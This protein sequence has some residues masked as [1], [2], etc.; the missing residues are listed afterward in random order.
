MKES[1]APAV[2]RRLNHA[3]RREKILEAAAKVFIEKG[4]KA[5]TMADLVFASGLSVGGFY[6]YY[7]DKAELLC[8][9]MQSGCAY[10]YDS[11][12]AFRAAHPDMPEKEM[13]AEMFLDKLL[14]DN[15]QK[16]IYMM[17]LG[18]MKG[19]SALEGLYERIVVK[20]RDEF[21][22][23]CEAAGMRM[24]KRLN[25]D[26]FMAMLNSLYLGIDRLGLHGV[27]S[28]HRDLLKMMLIDHMNEEERT[29]E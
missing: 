6:H 3:E 17:F 28:R 11:M 14:D 10:R 15:P 7:R 19:D 1:S 13:I 18:E 24:L 12:T 16:R 20:S 23:F 9:L 29:H 22:A 25:T 27:L 2:R 8:D 4:Y 5:C 21:D 26:F